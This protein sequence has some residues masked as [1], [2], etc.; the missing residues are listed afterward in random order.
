MRSPGAKWSY[1]LM[2][3]TGLKGLRSCH[4]LKPNRFAIH[5]YVWLVSV[6]SNQRPSDDRS[7]T[8]TDMV[9]VPPLATVDP[10]AGSVL[11]TWRNPTSVDSTG[12]NKT[13]TQGCGSSHSAARAAFASAGDWPE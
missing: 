10:E 9:T 7:P 13:F 5:E 12:T 2:S 8:D 4:G 1:F 11:I 6:V 3:S